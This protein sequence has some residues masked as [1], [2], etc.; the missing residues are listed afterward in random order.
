MAHPPGMYIPDAAVPADPG[1]DG[2]IE[3]DPHALEELKEAL[4]KAAALLETDRFADVELDEQAFGASATGRTLGA[5]HRVAH[6]IIADTIKGVVTDLWG[7]R[8]GVE[9]FESGMGNAD[10]TAT[11][12]LRST[13]EGIDALAQSANLDHGRQSYHNSQAN[14]LGERGPQTEPGADDA[15]GA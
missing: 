8:D 15:G 12:D 6:Q 9:K 11:A 5:E 10:Q 3:I 4:E 13:Q 2:S 14:N 7:Y 1:G